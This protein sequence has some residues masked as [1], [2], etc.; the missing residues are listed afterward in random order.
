MSSSD[1]FKEVVLSSSSTPS[2]NV[3]VIPFGLTIHRILLNKSQDLI[4]GPED[5]K[6]HERNGRCFFGPLVGRF[7]NRLPCGPSS[8]SAFKGPDINLPEW[9][10]EG[11]CHHGGPSKENDKVQGGNQAGPFDRLVWQ[12]LSSDQVTLFEGQDAGSSQDQSQ[13]VFSVTSPSDD[14]GFPGE[15]L[16]EARISLVAPSSSK[17]D[18]SVRLGQSAGSVRLEYRAKILNHSATATPLNLTHHW[19]FNLSASSNSAEAL[20][21]QGR[22]DDH[23]LF[24]PSTSEIGLKRLDLDDRG[25]PTGK[26]L[27]CPNGDKTGHGWSERGDNGFG[28]QVK[29][30]LPSDG[31]D[32]FYT[33][34]PSNVSQQTYLHSAS[35]GLTIAFKSNQTG[36]Q[37]YSANGQPPVSEADPKSSGGSKKTFHRHDKNDT[38]GNAQ[39]SAAFLEFGHPH[40]TFLHSSLQEF[41]NQDTILRD[42]QVYN[43]W[44]QAEIWTQ[45][46]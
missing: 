8:L 33:W 40:A 15:L 5:P 46:S 2:L 37:F 4:V 34:G 17:S 3:H 7:A 29:D 11:V 22:I 26:L 32:H 35:T 21:E 42:G 12:K 13:A 1:P 16:I 43:N 30:Q 25:V 20:K 36:L 44:V 31:Y 45:Q 10:G 19:G 6:D 27:E 23:Q 39:R 18:G 14:N 28:K 24:I 38:S 41:V 9:G